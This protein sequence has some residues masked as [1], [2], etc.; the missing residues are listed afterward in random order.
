[1]TTPNYEDDIETL[2]SYCETL[3]DECDQ[4]KAEIAILK[5]E[6]IR[7]NAHYEELQKNWSE[8]MQ[9]L[10]QM[11]TQLEQLTTRVHELKMR[12]P[13]V[14]E[15]PSHAEPVT[16][17]IMLERLRVAKVNKRAVHQAN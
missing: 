15:E 6:N 11:N 17:D 13:M 5:E 9:M 14:L 12:T 10:W 16:T 7:V 4:H 8:T 1:M 2:A 3:V